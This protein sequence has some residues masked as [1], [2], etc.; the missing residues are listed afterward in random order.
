[1]VVSLLFSF[2]ISLIFEKALNFKNHYDNLTEIHNYLIIINKLLIQNL[3]KVIYNISI[4]Q[5]VD[6]DFDIIADLYA[7]YAKI[8]ELPMFIEEHRLED[9]IFDIEKFDVLLKCKEKLYICKKKMNLI[10]N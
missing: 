8:A 3:F 5:T 10:L 6:E 4:M 7:I 1:M 2:N 9:Y